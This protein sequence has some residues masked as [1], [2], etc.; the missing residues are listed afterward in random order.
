MSKPLRII[1]A[2]GPED[3]VEAYHCWINKEDTPSQVSVAFSSQFYDVCQELDA[4][5]Y[6]IASSNQKEF[7]K[8][9]GFIVEHRPLLSSGAK[10]IL[11]HLGYIGN[12]LLLLLQAIRFKA[13][14]VVVDSGTTYWFVLSLFSGFGIKV[15]PS[16]HCL[17]WRKYLPLRLIDKL[18]VKLSTNLFAR[19]SQAILVASEDIS[20]QISELT[21]GKHRPILEF[22]S[23]YRRAD[24]ADINESHPEHSPFQI[25]FAGRVEQN[26]GVFDLLEIAKR[27]A[28]DRLDIIFNICGEGSALESLRRQTIQAGINKS[29]IFHGYCSKSQ[30]REM[31]RHSHVVIVPTRTN[32]SEG[33]NRVVCESI[34]SGRPVVTSAVC[35]ALSYVREAVMEVPPN[36]I[37]AY[38]DALLSLYGDRQL[39]E[40]KKQRCLILQEKFYDTTKSWGTALKSILL[41]IKSEPIN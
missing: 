17:L 15:I 2:L 5:C 33:F 8:S 10:G 3:A 13:N 27:F 25:L 7:V 1:Y 29:F 9:E 23:T 14:V 36:D 26:K 31:Y 34:L 22:L 32:F 39:Y 30:M 16:L 37:R 38:G 28:V 18:N 6:V 24:F 11:F 40:Q 41:S 4:S 19:D 12:G 21:N 35:P 20:K